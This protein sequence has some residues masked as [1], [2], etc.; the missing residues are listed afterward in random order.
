MLLA[1]RQQPLLRGGLQR[2]QVWVG[3]TSA[4]G[5]SD[6]GLC[7]KHKWAAWLGWGVC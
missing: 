4:P 3:D 7:G 1:G 5:S 6:S 2:A